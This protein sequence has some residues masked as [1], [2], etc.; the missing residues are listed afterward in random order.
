[1]NN[2]NR[3]A[4]VGAGVAGLAL[5]IL[6]TKR[7]HKITVYERASSVCSIGAGVTLW[8]NAMFVLQQLGL[9]SEVTRAGG[10]PAYM[11]HFNHYGVQQGEFDIEEVNLLCGFPSVTILRRDLMKILVKAFTDLGGTI[12]LSC[13]IKAQD[14][15]SLKQKFDLVVGADGRMNSAV[16]QFLY[17][18]TVTP[19]YHG[20]INIIGVSKLS[21]DSVSN[22]ICDFRDNAE[23][24][25]IVPVKQGWCYWAAAWNTEIARERTLA[26]W[27]KEVHARF[28]NW[29]KPVRSVLNATD[30]ATLNR[31]F[32][33]DLEPLPYWHRDN[34]VIIGDA[35]HA[36]L[37]TSGQGACQAL[38]DAWHLIQL[39]HPEVELN[40]ALT[41]FYQQRF[42]KTTAAQT[43]GRQVAQKIFVEQTEPQSPSNISAT[44]LS[45]FWMQGL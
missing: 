12:R 45:Q 26:D 29:P 42:T 35:A 30:K 15:V 37:P 32:V 22:T 8:P 4:I 9:E 1:M 28:K 7:G 43:V 21:E 5:A 17:P 36:P 16:R 14:I 33:H 19:S 34:V 44:Q 25:G 13:S 40:D 20:F 3:I 31:I 23:R 6:A 2:I 38:E 39:L 18:K 24:F 10:K 11:R 27:Q 41:R